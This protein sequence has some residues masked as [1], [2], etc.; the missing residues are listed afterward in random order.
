MSKRKRPSQR[1]SGQHPPFPRRAGLWM[2]LG[3]TALSPA[4]ALVGAFPANINLSALNGTNGF[5]ISGVAVVDR[6]GTAVSTAGDVNGDGVDDL[7]IGAPNA[8][9]NGYDSGTSYVVFG[10][11]TPP[12]A[13]NPCATAAATTGCTVNGVPDQLCRGTSKRDLI[14][15]TAGNDVIV[16]LH[17]GDNLQGRRGDD[18]LCGGDGND[19]LIGSLGNDRLFGEAGDDTLRANAG[20]DLFQ[21]GEGNDSLKGNEGDDQLGGGDGDDA[22]R[23]L[24]GNETL[25]GGAGKGLVRGGPDADTLDGGPG[26]DKVNGGAGQDTCTTDSEDTIV[27][28]CA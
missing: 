6:L 28:F 13:P 16:G 18:L 25:D 1:V 8:D 20:N 24:E 5:R 3:L 27:V 7:L 15:G 21:G 4:A 26:P 11:A 12:P 19:R 9:P 22:L 23:G 2:A 17:G 14:I 10:R